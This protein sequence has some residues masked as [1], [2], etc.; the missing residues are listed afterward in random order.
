MTPPPRALPLPCP[1]N[2]FDADSAMS[3]SVWFN[4]ELL[5][6]NATLRRDVGLVTQLMD[7]AVESMVGYSAAWLGRPAEQ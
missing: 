2:W 3:E 6:G 7:A 1:Q 4:Q 5:A